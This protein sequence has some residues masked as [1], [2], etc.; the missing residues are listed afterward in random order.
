[1]ETQGIGNFVLLGSCFGARTALS[2][3]ASMGPSLRGIVL[4]AAPLRD[5]GGLEA[6][7]TKLALK[8]N[9]WDYLQRG[10]RVRVVRGLFDRDRRRLYTSLAKGKWKAIAAKQRWRAASEREDDVYPLS[11]KFVEPLVYLVQRRVPVLFVYG[12]EDDEYVDFQQAKGGRLGDLLER[13][14][15]LIEVKTLPG[16]VHG[17]ASVAVQD[18]ILRMVVAWLDGHGQMPEIDSQEQEGIQS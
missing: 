10:L 2:Y 18:E 6:F 14:S 1:M 7:S 15:P 4:I 3:A 5:Y 16:R 9:F 8:W 11:G 13:G 17:L 12:T